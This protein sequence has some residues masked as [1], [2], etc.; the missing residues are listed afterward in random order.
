VRGFGCAPFLYAYGGISP[1]AL[2][3]FTFLHAIQN[4]AFLLI[5]LFQYGKIISQRE[6]VKRTIYETR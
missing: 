4:C 2:F 3:Y 5:F 6:K 1:L